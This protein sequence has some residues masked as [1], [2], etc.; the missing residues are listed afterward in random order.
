MGLRPAPQYDT[1]QFTGIADIYAFTL[2]AVEL[3]KSEEA[4][5]KSQKNY[6]EELKKVNLQDAAIIESIQ[7]IFESPAHVSA[8]P[9]E[10]RQDMLL[11]RMEVVRGK[12]RRELNDRSDL[13][14]IIRLYETF[15]LKL[16]EQ[17]IKALNFDTQVDF[18]DVEKAQV[19]LTR[20]EESLE[21]K[22]KTVAESVT[23]IPHQYEGFKDEAAEKMAKDFLR[24]WRGRAKWF[25]VP[26][27]IYGIAIHEMEERLMVQ[28]EKAYK[29][30][31]CKS[32]KKMYAPATIRRF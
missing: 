11:A 16:F 9:A 1:S 21:A 20:S 17:D 24:E 19:R 28:W 3:E 27:T 4:L 7:E 12:R 32:E 30:A 6:E 10:A 13:K 26:V 29:A 8:L 25:G 15:M 2:A 18:T 23:R 14:D 5:R 22:K 31:G